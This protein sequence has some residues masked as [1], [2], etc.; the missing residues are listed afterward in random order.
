M[1]ER[2]FPVMLERGLVSA[3]GSRLATPLTAEEAAFLG[4]VPESPCPVPLFVSGVCASTFDVAWEL[5]RTCAMPPWSGVLAVAQ[6][7]GR[8]QLRREWISPPGNLH[9]SFFLP[10]DMERLGNMAPLAM[11]YC[12]HRALRAMGIK[13][14]LKW[15]NDLLL[16]R[17]GKE[18][19]FGG[20][21]LEERNG[22]LLA[23]LGLNLR[24]A[25]DEGAMRADRAVPAVSL[26]SFTGSVFA[27][28]R[29]LVGAMRENHAR[30]IA[31]ASRE[32]LRRRIE[33]S[34]A[35]MGRPVYAEDGGI[36]GLVRGLAADGSLALQTDAGPAVVASGGIRPL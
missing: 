17:A 21:L 7:N 26:P 8:G 12:V 6:T 36:R 22:R 20:L 23:G 27:F 13:T 5:C 11:G 31:G 9:V 30:R 19:K 28:W 16:R 33:T 29:S 34:L 14:R 4:F 35:W 24:H 25:P 3:D 15:P 10:P 18:G 32:I 1:K 2:F